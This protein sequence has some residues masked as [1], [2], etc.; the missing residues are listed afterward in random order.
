MSSVI[1][2]ADK[3]NLSLSLSLSHIILLFMVHMME[4]LYF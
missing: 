4:V 1:K 2:K 3:L